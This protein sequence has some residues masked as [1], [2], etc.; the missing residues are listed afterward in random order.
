MTGDGEQ[1][2]GR[3]RDL[4]LRSGRARRCDTERSAVVCGAVRCSV[5]RI[6]E[7]VALRG[8]QANPGAQGSL[9]VSIMEQL[10]LGWGEEAW[11]CGS[12]EA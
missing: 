10:G 5:V 9:G 8:K 2:K 4:D 7:R 1:S 3:D 12:A 6:A 11:S